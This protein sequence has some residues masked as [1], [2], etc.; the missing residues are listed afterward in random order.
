[1]T[2]LAVGAGLLS[3]TGA[4]SAVADSAG[5]PSVTLKGEPGPRTKLAVPISAD[6]SG[7]L[8]YGVDSGERFTW[9]RPDGTIVNGLP[10]PL[11]LGFLW[12]VNGRFGLE[13]VGTTRTYRI[14][15]YDTGKAVRFDLPTGDKATTVF[16]ENRVMTLRNTHGT[17]SL[18]LLEIPAA[19]GTP[20]D[21]PV[22]GVPD[23]LPGTVT[24]ALVDSRGA[25]ID[26]GGSTGFHALL[27]FATGHLTVVP[28]PRTSA[29]RLASLS[30]TGL[31]YDSSAD[32]DRY[33]VDRDHPD[34]PPTLLKVDSTA[35]LKLVGDWAVYPAADGRI[36]AQPA[37][38]GAVRTLLPQSDMQPVTGADGAVYVAGG[39]GPDD[40]A[41]RR[42]SIGADGTAVVG[43]LVPLPR[44][45]VYDVGGV[46][47]DQ[48]QLRV[49]TLHVPSGVS[50][51]STY[52]TGSAL[53]LTAGGTLNATPA[54]NVG[55]LGWHP[56]DG[57]P[58]YDTQCTEECLRLVGTGE[59]D[60]VRNNAERLV[61]TL[62]A[63]G[64]FSIQR[65]DA[66]FQYVL[67]GTKELSHTDHWHAASLWGSQLWSAGTRSGTVSAVSLPSMKAL[68]SPVSVGAPCTPEEIQVVGRW[69][70]WSCGPT[71][72]AGVYDRTTK[73]VITVPSGYAELADGYL[74]SQNAAAAELEITYFPGAVPAARVG[75]TALAPLKDQV[76]AP[77]DRRGRFWAVDRFGGPVAF[78]TAAG[79]VTVKWPQVTTSPLTVIATASPTAVDL[80]ADGSRYTGVWHL[81]KPASG[82]KL[83]ITDGGGKTVRTL[84]GGRADGKIS[85]TWDGTGT[86]GGKVPT[87]TYRWTLTA[88]AADPEGKSATATGSLAVW[89]SVARR[90]DF[91]KDGVGDIVTT[92]TAGRLAIQ[93]GDGHG[94]I[95]SAHKT[96]T[97]GWPK[98]SSPIPFGDMNGD[99]CAD[100]LIRDSTGALTRYDGG[101]GTAIAPTSAHVRLGTGFNAY[102][103]LT[104]PGDL[105]G[106]GRADLLAR[107]TAGVLWTFPG[108]ATGGLGTRVKGAPGQQ[109]YQRLVGAGDLN[110]DGIGD[111][112][113]QDK[114]G[115]LWRLLGNGK[116]G[117]APRTRLASG[118]TSYNAL[119]VPGDLTGD[120]RPDLVARDT[121]GRLWRLNGT[122]TGSFA[123]RTQIAT[124][125]Q[126]YLYV[127]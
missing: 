24:R 13:Q 111:V 123:P 69:I 64:S 121:A 126:S 72:K 94:G 31:L 79:D 81:S 43:V 90:H 19:G 105:T 97:D 110:G 92:D 116:S 26:F 48:G 62:S 100:L 83:T 66:R 12:G 67:D 99:G 16:G 3:W 14:R 36:L 21:R 41:V 115:V 10:K 75:T 71:G 38:G 85:A 42:I 47:V 22:S 127:T 113:A 54:R 78:L 46:A 96:L 1:M 104:S 55:D 106:D 77:A 95:D 101:C 122:S 102:D 18:H 82:W 65:P 59:G 108:T 29:T 30:A 39:S 33:L 8:S 87:G 20:V 91:G 17:W 49:G 60:V 120:G 74:V 76:D 37:A 61:P 125:W 7:F 44:E 80:R 70:Y 88:R 119:V 103:V 68:G 93:P 6:G 4:D 45:T 25:A 118:S 50:R 52:L 109:I 35:S 32:A 98:G 2:A 86:D 73:H 84:T 117:L 40:W 28:E 112:I 27:D 53:S 114:A 11:Q 9:V 5:L 89:S 15:N 107:D 124:N 58:A 23:A 34:A 51:A 56:P 57:E 63:S